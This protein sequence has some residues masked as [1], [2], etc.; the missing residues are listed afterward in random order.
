MSD[1]CLR[2]EAK[3][4]NGQKLTNSN[5]KDLKLLCSV[6]WSGHYHH[7]LCSKSVFT[8]SYSSLQLVIKYSLIASD[9]MLSARVVKR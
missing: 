9:I 5:R 8:V 6:E 4:H 7:F 2:K 1:Y 3:Y